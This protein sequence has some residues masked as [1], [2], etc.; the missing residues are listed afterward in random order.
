MSQSAVLALGLG[1]P[2]IGTAVDGALLP[3]LSK[4]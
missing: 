2:I 4:V 3:A 1:I